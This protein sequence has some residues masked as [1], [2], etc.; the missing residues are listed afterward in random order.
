MITGTIS[1]GTLRPQDLIPA[2]LD[3]LRA[4]A[5]A[6]YAAAMA[7]PDGF[8][9]RVIDAPADDSDWWHG[10][11][12]QALLER[13]TDALESSA[14]EG[15]YFGAHPGDGSDFGFWP[16]EERTPWPAVSLNASG[17]ISPERS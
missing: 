17:S 8:A 7:Q 9:I 3:A 2:F 13:L 5:L 4:V 14:P 12:A 16:I 15:H 1:H 10:D 11:E 6:A